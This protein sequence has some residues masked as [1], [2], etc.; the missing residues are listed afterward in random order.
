M[1]VGTHLQFGNWLGPTS[2]ADFRNFTS[3]LTPLNPFEIILRKLEIMTRGVVA[4]RS[5]GVAYARRPACFDVLWYRVS[6]GT[7]GRRGVS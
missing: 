7:C 1:E 2:I 6:R 5:R 4:G 3:P